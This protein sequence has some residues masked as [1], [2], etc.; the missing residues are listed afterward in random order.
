MAQCDS[1]VEQG[2]T[3]VDVY[4]GDGATYALLP[5]HTD[6]PTGRGRI[7]RMNC[8]HGHEVHVWLPRERVS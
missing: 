2:R 1:C 4:E 3:Q 5:A 8:S 6:R 7:M